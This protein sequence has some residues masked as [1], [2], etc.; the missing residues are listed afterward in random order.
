MFKKFKYFCTALVF[1][2]TQLLF[3]GC[4][5]ERVSTNEGGR[6]QIKSF[7]HCSCGN[8]SNMSLKYSEDRKRSFTDQK[9]L[10]IL[11]LHPK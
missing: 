1:Q 4:A 7:T 10:E 11:V 9:I 5:S 3:S 8:S 6:T 2:N